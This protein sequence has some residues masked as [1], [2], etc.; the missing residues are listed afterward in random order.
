VLNF[1]SPLFPS[2]PHRRMILPAATAAALWGVPLRT[3]NRLYLA[4]KVP[5]PVM[6]SDDLIGWRLF[7]LIDAKEAEATRAKRAKELTSGN[8]K[9]TQAACG[10]HTPQAA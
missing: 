4:G 9:V 7:E 1:D 5:P 6:V 8:P 3:W 10:N 2:N